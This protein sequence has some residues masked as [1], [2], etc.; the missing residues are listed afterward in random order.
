MK[1]GGP[2]G[3]ETHCT[4]GL[5][6]KGPPFCSSEDVCFSIP[7]GMKH[8]MQHQPFHHACQHHHMN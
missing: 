1:F 7:A 4:V 5:V 8:T 3:Y 2:V 6:T